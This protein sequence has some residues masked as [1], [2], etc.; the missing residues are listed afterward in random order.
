MF[1]GSFHRVFSTEHDEERKQPGGRLAVALVYI[2]PG[3]MG[4]GLVKWH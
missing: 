4:L 1:R 2:S 3:D